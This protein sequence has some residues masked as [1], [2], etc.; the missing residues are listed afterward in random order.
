MDM[1]FDQYIQNP[2]GVKNAVFSNREMY[3]ELYTNKLNKI[4]VREAGKIEY[5]LYKGKGKYY[6]YIKV[7]SE[8]VENFYYD[9]V[10]EFTE[11]KGST[12]ISLK[13]YN[14][15]FYSN[16]PAFVFTFAHAF[17]ENELFIDRYK[18][19]MSKEAVKKVA[20]EKN[21]T[22]Q[23][24]YVKSLY[25][26]Y[27]IMVQKGLFNKLLYVST[28]SERN[29]KSMIM[30]ADKKIA[31]RQEL[32]NSKEKAP[33]EKKTSLPDPIETTTKTINKI[34]HTK[35]IKQINSTKV[36]KNLKRTKTVK[37]I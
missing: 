28:Y 26:A 3:R 37:K 2:M 15:H 17:I 25:F 13:N 5:Y 34:A 29:V 20:K 24:G 10:I 1:T 32:G 36:S 35:T 19:K 22:N 14:V 9:V 31:L 21:P 33:K 23:V 30:D 4:L 11:P 7:P 18:D 8:M 6:A 12:P 16:D 27:L